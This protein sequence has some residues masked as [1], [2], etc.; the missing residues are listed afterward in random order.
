[1]KKWSKEEL[2]K[3]IDLLKNGFKYNEIAEQL[4]RTNRSIK[5]KLEE[6]GLRYYD[7]NLTTENRKCIN[8]NCE[9]EVLKTEIKKFCGSSCAA[10]FNN[11]IS[12]RKYKLFVNCKNCSKEIKNNRGTRQYC[13]GF[14]RGDFEKGQKFE[15]IKKGNISLDSSWYKRYLIQRD[16]EQCM[17]C[18]WSEKN[19]F[20]NTVPIELEHID[21]NSENNKLDNLKL[22]CPNCH[23][24]TPTYKALNKGN[25]RHMRQQRYKDGKSY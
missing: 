17:D 20:S 15:L 1:M 4:D 2:E 5:N 13:D 25:G 6:I 21:G 14:C 18:G 12:K 23:S 3:A 16:G 22:L 11:K 9:F 8:C 10:S 24:L 19:K 7:F